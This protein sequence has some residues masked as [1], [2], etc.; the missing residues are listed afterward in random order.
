[1]FLGCPPNIVALKSETKVVAKSV[2]DVADMKTTFP[3]RRANEN[4]NRDLYFIIFDL[5]L[6]K[7]V[8]EL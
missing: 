1:L 5:S 7:T 2:P 6:K 4:K 3:I 8:V